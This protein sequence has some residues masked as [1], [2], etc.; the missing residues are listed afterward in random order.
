MLQRRL[1]F[2][3]AA[4]HEFGVGGKILCMGSMAFDE[5]VF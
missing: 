2:P 4:M 5:N 3:I 1:R